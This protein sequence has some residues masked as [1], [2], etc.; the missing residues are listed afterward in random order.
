MVLFLS[1][2]LERSLLLVWLLENHVEEPLAYSFVLSS[3]RA[4]A[5]TELD[6]HGH[7]TIP[8]LGISICRWK[9]LRAL[10][11]RA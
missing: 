6:G 2:L 3:T 4:A 7:Q 11:V 1:L 9:L 10:S 8:H 5:E